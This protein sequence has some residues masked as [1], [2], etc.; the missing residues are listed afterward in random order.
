MCCNC[1]GTGHPARLCLTPSDHA[2]QTVDEEGDTDEESSEEGDVCGVEWKCG[3]NGAN[4][5]DDD[6]LGIGWE[7][8]E[9]GKW[10]RLATVVDSGAA[11]NVYEQTLVKLR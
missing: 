7:S 9:H 11:E 3:L 6:I 2:T 5:E 8:K 10:D 1:G 4:D